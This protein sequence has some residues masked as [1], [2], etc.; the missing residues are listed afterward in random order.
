M[1]ISKIWF[2][3]GGIPED[4]RPDAD[5]VIPRFL[6]EIG[7][8]YID[9]VLLHCVTDRIGTRTSQTDGYPGEVQGERCDIA[10][11]GFRPFNCIAWKRRR[12]N[13]G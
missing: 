6:K 1:I 13:R 5:V 2:K 3:P 8:D 12:P 4:E 7:T 11:T 9:L 10:R